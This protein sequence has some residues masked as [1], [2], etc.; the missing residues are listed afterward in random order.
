MTSTGPE[1]SAPLVPPDAGPH[2]R[3]VLLKLSGEALSGGT[4][5]AETV[6]NTRGQNGTHTVTVT[7]DP[8]NA[9]VEKNESNNT[10]SRVATVQG[11]NVTLK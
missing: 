11:G 4:G 5:R 10:A 8:A 6:W 2:W 9:I 3:R 1:P 7:V